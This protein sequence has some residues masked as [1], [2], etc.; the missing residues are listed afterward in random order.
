MEFKLILSSDDQSGHLDFLPLVS[1]GWRKW[2][3]VKIALALLS[4]NGD[5]V[6][7]CLQYVDEVTRFPYIPNTWVMCQA[8]MARLWYGAEHGND[9]CYFNDMDLVPLQRDWNAQFIKARQPGQL[10]MVGSDYYDPIPHECGKIP[11]GMFGGESSLLREFINPSGLNYLDFFWSWKGVK[12]FD[13]RED[14]TG[15]EACFS[16]ESVVRVMLKRWGKKDQVGVRCT[17]GRYNAPNILDR[18]QWNCDRDTLFGGGYWEGH[19]PKP[20]KQNRAL[21]EPLYEYIGIPC[22]L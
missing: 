19:L 13:N 14:P 3:D 22:N 9:I 16:D 15:H 18:A 5:F 1:A 20:P 7:W 2:F 21:L 8:K 17:R 12:E 6:P 11:M 4:D 10:L